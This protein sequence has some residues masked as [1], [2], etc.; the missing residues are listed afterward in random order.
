MNS[1]V[2]QK[3]TLGGRGNVTRRANASEVCT[4]IICPIARWSDIMLGLLLH[5]QKLE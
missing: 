5:R 3:K 2:Q 1:S 4:Q